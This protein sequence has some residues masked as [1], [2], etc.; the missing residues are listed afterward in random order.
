MA[1]TRRS[2]IAI[3]VSFTF[4]FALFNLR[5]LPQSHRA[6]PPPPKQQHPLGPW[7]QHRPVQHPV[8]SLIPLPTGK[9]APIPTI[10]HQFEEESPDAKLLR[11]ARRQAVRESFLHTWQGYKENAWL[12]D[13]V[14]PLDGE[15]IN[16][17]GGWAATLVDS[18]DSLWIMGLKAQFEEAVAALEEIDFS[19]T[20]MEELPVFEITIRYLGGL[21]AAYD[22]TNG[23]YPIILEKAISVG[24][25]LYVAFD[26]PNHMPVLRWD[27]RDAKD[28]EPQEAATDSIMAELGSLSVEFTRLSQITQDPKYFDAVQRITDVFEEHQNKTRLPG[29]WPMI[30]DAAGPGF[31]GDRRFNLGGMSDSMYE[32]LPKQYL[33]LGGLYPQYKAMYETAIDV[34]KKYLLF[35]PMTPHGDD[36]LISGNARVTGQTLMEVNAEGEHL[37]CFAGGMVALAAKIF[38]RE[39][40]LDI[41]RKLT[42]GCI[43][44]YRS[45][46][47]GI[48]PEIFRVA[49]CEDETS[50][51]R[52]NATM[53]FLSDA[54]ENPLDE[55][56]RKA[57]SLGLI[58]GFRSISDKAYQLRPEAIESVFILYRI[59]GDHTL[60][61]KAWDM[62]TAIDTH[63]KTDIAYA[64]LKD[65][66]VP[67][68]PMHNNMQSFWTGETLKYFYLLYS[69]PDLVSLDE[70]VFNTEA[71]PLKR[72]Q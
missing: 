51:C 16:P 9:P 15:A 24:N 28:L 72:P 7:W 43:W 46:P 25:L 59:T 14:R 21:L 23:K 30:V 27:W 1:C 70:Y 11:L 40:D 12:H 65:V 56:E 69:E 29:M 47:S 62:F 20:Y 49:A 60:Q 3:I 52:W 50:G 44:A 35:R 26:T 55:L 64:A 6:R 4:I 34:A 48:M 66:T 31:K 33:L 67:H 18:L 13:E 10:Q 54:E 63:C 41:A 39:D 45:M 38:E 57:K 71:H 37:T 36:I 68:P 42:E 58:P 32:Y 5:S 22:L 17:F 8:A 53:W 2:T 61:D 19:L